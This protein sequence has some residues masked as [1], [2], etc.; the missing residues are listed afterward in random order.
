[1]AWNHKKINLCHETLP[2]PGF[3]D[4]MTF[5]SSSTYFL[6]AA[7]YLLKCSGWWN[8]ASLFYHNIFWFTTKEKVIAHVISSSYLTSWKACILKWNR[9]WNI[10]LAFH[11]PQQELRYHGTKQCWVDTGIPWWIVWVLHF[12]PRRI[13]HTIP[14]ENLE[15]DVSGV[16]GSRKSCHTVVGLAYPTWT[17][18]E[19]TKNKQILVTVNKTFTA[20]FFD[21]NCEKNFEIP[22]SKY[23]NRNG[24]MLSILEELLISNVVYATV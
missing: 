4:K 1:M 16:L 22:F 2:V 24:S 3:K 7:S 21:K 20:L 6:I 18:E 5:F 13:L 11:Y 14:Q 12:L 8:S 23:G 9:K 17:G 10:R 15:T 19:L